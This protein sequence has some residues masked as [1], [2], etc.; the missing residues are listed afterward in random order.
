LKGGGIIKKSVAHNQDAV[1]IDLER[2]ER[3]SKLLQ[4]SEFNFFQLAYERWYGRNMC[5]KR[6]E[7]IFTDYILKN[8]VPHWARHCARDVLSRYSR[9]LL[10]VTEYGM[11]GN[12]S[13]F[14]QKEHRSFL[15][16]VMILT[17][18]IFYL[19]LSGYINF[20]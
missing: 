8:E 16:A 9:G 5:E 13:A 4:I 15:A 3:S 6:M 20:R 11:E 14:E 12:H 18:L 19:I 10:D 7:R 17:Y 1:E 2:V